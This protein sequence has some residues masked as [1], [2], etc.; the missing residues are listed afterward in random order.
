MIALNADAFDCVLFKSA[1][2]AATLT[3]STLTSVTNEISATGGY[4]VHGRAMVSPGFTV[5]AS[6][7]PD[8]SSSARPRCSRP[9]AAH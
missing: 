8:T 7:K 9:M 2:N 1:S 5:G 4:V 6:A 3:L